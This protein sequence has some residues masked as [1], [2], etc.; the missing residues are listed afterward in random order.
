MS[1]GRLGCT[2]CF[3][4]LNP[5]DN[6]ADLCLI[7][8]CVECGQ[9]YH[10]ICWNHQ[11][12]CLQCGQSQCQ[13]VQITPPAV[14][15]VVT[16]THAI[17]ITP[18]ATVVVRPQSRTHSKRIVWVAFIGI[19]LVTALLVLRFGTTT[20]APLADLPSMPD[21]GPDVAQTSAARSPDRPV[22]A[23]NATRSSN[24]AATPTA[25]Q[26]HTYSGLRVVFSRGEVNCS[27][28]VV[29]DAE[30]GFE[31]TLKSGGNSEEPSWSPDGRQIVASSSSCGNGNR[32]LFI[33]SLEDQRTTSIVQG[34][35]NIDPD[36]GGDD[37]IYFARGSK[38]DN[39]DLYSVK[40]NGTDLRLLGETGRQPTLSP[41]GHQV[42]FMRVNR[43]IW[44]IWVA[45]LG[46]N[47]KLINSRQI[48]FPSVS[49]GVHARMP[50]WSAD[51]SFIIFSMT[52]KNF[53]SLAL[54]GVELS[55]GKRYAWSG[56]SPN[57]SQFERPAC[58]RGDLC[59]SAESEGGL[60]LL[61]QAGGNYSMARQITTNAKDWGADIY[62]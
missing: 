48:A 3:R 33:L 41:D 44:R 10:A 40:P 15:P 8:K 28:L 25:Q 60:W 58:G 54:G 32:S 23:F 53:K 22:T 37:R 38:A 9:L 31:T 21:T 24:F 16:K 52:D 57:G 12:K 62:P 18:A 13:Q 43:G 19:A 42:A 55:T 34:G 1:N 56:A 6:E 30:N 49:D 2:W 20:I 11:Q 45:T 51:G 59:V 50:N 46:T 29:L 35:N 14:M 27:D 39:A 47:G 17:P 4:T 5:Q 7:V 61:N 26:M 36:W